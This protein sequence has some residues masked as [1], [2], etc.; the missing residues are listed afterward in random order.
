MP[1][2]DIETRAGLAKAEE[3][4]PE[5][6]PGAPSDGGDKQ[7][8]ERIRAGLFRRP[9]SQTESSAGNSGGFLGK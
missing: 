5:A 9:F 4:R 1:G 7:K 6:A 2:G 8:N 3:P